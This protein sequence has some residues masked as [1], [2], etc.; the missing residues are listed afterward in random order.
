MTADD[1]ATVVLFAF[2]VII[3]RKFLAELFKVD[4]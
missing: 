1:V 3:A 4:L 2:A